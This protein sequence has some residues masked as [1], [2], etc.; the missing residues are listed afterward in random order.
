MGFVGGGWGVGWG[1]EFAAVP[2]V[3]GAA[4]EGVVGGC[5]VAVAAGRFAV[6]VF[7]GGAFGAAIE[8]EPDHGV[9][10]VD[11]GLGDV[12]AVEGVGVGGVAELPDDGGDLV[13]GGVG[14]GDEGEGAVGL[15]EEGE[16]WRWDGGAR[17][18]GGDCG[19]GRRGVRGFGVAA[20]DQ[21]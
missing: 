14:D 7:F 17:D 13:V 15:V 3:V 8:M 4:A 20:D 2:V 10:R 11:Y 9:A 1:E 19:G 5:V 16:G 12:E 18:G 21:K 6:G